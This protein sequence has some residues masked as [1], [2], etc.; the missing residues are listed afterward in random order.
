[1]MKAREFQQAVVTLDV[2]V[3]IVNGFPVFS[4]EV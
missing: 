1:M 2:A 3:V 4:K